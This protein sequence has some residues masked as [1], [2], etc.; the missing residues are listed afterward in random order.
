MSEV[1][2]PPQPSTAGRTL[3][4]GGQQLSEKVAAY[5]RE[6]IMVGQF[7]A[8]EYVRTEHLATELGVSPTPV[9]EGLMILHSE[10][11]IRWVPRKGYRV[12]P[13]TAS[14]VADIFKVQAF[15]AG[16][17]AARAAVELTD[18]SRGAI[19]RWQEQLESADTAGKADEVDRLNFEIH[20]T[21]NKASKSLRMGSLLNLTVNFVPLRFFGSI[22]GWSAAS[23]HDHTDILDALRDRDP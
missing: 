22:P 2:P 23:V 4:G 16:E 19:E 7:R 12:V 1:V 18:E 3:F 10:G 11:T 14:D 20:R 5:V 9:R 21:I 15:I 8:G 13:I 17:L 6:G